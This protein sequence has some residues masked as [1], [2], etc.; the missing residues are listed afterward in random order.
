[1]NNDKS[2]CPTIEVFVII[3]ILDVF[4]FYLMVFITLRSIVFKHVSQFFNFAVL[5]CLIVTVPYYGVAPCL[6]SEVWTKFWME[7]MFVVI[8]V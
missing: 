4:N 8:V 3:N 1:M 5:F 7:L 6:F 2:Y